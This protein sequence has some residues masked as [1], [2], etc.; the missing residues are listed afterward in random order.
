MTTSEEISSTSGYTKPASKEGNNQDEEDEFGGSQG[1]EIIISDDPIKGPEFTETVGSKVSSVSVFHL[2]YRSENPKTA[3][4]F[5]NV[6]TKL[7]RVIHCS[8]T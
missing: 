1:E 8:Q 5:F 4:Q 6:L 2:Q 7:C 3:C